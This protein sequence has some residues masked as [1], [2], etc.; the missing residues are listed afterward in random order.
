MPEYTEEEQETI[1][2]AV[3]K[4]GG[5]EPTPIIASI[6]MGGATAASV[7]ALVDKQVG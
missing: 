3:Q 6:A 7:S 5:N 2:S 1:A 4:Q